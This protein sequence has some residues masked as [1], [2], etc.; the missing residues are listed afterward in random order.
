MS[1]YFERKS[2]EKAKDVSFTNLQKRSIVTRA[3][4]FSRA[5]SRLHEIALNFDWFIELS[6]LCDWLELLLWFSFTTPN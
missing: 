4:T 1:L 5:F 6:V 3:N 2:K